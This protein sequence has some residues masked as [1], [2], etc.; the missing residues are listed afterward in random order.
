LKRRS[1]KWSLPFRFPD[2]N[3]VCIF[4]PS[5]ACYMPRLSCPPWLKHRSNIWWSVQVIC[6][7]LDS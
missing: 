1:S 5:H 6:S 3:I 2:Q 4:H 7:W